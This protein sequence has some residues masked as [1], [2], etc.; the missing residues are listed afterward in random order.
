MDIGIYNGVS[1]TISLD[2]ELTADRVDGLRLELALLAVHKAR[3]MI[4]DCSRLKALDGTGVGA[5]AFVFKRRKA[6]GHVLRLTGLTGQ[7]LAALRSHGLLPV[8]G[9]VDAAAP[10]PAA[11]AMVRSRLVHRSAKRE[12]AIV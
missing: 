8:L 2:G 7:P 3:E 4:F 10:L 5:I 1:V 6:R 12:R 11:R 9:A